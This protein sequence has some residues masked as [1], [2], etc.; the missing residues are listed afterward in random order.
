MGQNGPATA[1]TRHFNGL[2]QQG[3]RVLKVAHGGRGLAPTS[4]AE[5]GLVRLGSAMAVEIPI[6]TSL[7]LTKG[8]ESRPEGPPC[9]T[10]P[11]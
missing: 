11:N 7:S 3:G 1:T 4:R 9:V 8:G 5:A 2:G 10:A 6:S